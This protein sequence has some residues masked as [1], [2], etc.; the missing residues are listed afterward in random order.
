MDDF[1]A[2]PGAANGYGLIGGEANAIAPQ[3]RPL[4]SMT[5]VLVLDNKKPWLAT[6]SPGGARIISIVYHFLINRILYNMNIAAATLAPR[7]HH[8]WLPDHLNLEYGFSK[9]TATLLEK[10]G[11]SIRYFKPWGSV[12]SVEW[13]DGFYYGFSDPRRPG[14][15]AKGLFL[16][17]K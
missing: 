11:H 17:K 16:D 2:K 6:G 15:L 14:A 7:M 3:K 1:S 8:Q 10:K 13:R 4:S 5:P 12:Q 9:D